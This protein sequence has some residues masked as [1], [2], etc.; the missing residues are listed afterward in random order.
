[1]FVGKVSLRCLILK[2]DLQMVLM[3]MRIIESTIIFV[4]VQ[5]CSLLLAIELVFMESG[6]TL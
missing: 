2:E 6:H 3:A 4:W 1:M 5:L